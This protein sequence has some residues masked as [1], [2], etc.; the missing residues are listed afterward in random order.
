M[1]DVRRRDRVWPRRGIMA[2]EAGRRVFGGVF[3]LTAVSFVLAMCILGLTIAISLMTG[4]VTRD[5]ARHLAVGMSGGALAVGIAFVLLPLLG[6]ISGL[7]DD[8]RMLELCDPGAP[9]LRRLMEQAPGTYNHSIAAGSMAEAA[10]H[11]IG[12]NALLTRVGA[13]YHDIG[14]IARPRFFAENQMGIPNPHDA[15][16]PEQSAF[17]I[18]AHVRDGVEMARKARL[19]VPVIDIIAQHH[20]TS[21]VSYFYRKASVFDAVIDQQ[22]FRYE[23]VLPSSREAAL[24]MLADAAEAAGRVMTDTGAAPIEEAVRRI[25]LSKAEDGQLA[26]SGMSESDMEAVVAVYA[27]ML[28]GFR[29]ARVDYAGM[30]RTNDAGQ[31]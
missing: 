13:Y 17:I 24:V 1:A 11:E 12:A 26:E 25:V 6:R 3:W 10:A 8:I 23:G 19:P 7:G 31:G 27:K 20:G 15:A 30:E 5:S 22:P 28:A 29:H 4:W 2:S 18:T 14:K 21:L 16:Q 9:L